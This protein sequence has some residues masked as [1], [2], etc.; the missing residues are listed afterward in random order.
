MNC[1]RLVY[2]F[3]LQEIP[4][5]MAYVFIDSSQEKI[6]II[7]QD[8]QERY[9][10]Q[11]SLNVDQKSVGEGW[12]HFVIS[13]ALQ[14]DDSIGCILYDVNPYNLHVFLADRISWYHQVL[15]KNVMI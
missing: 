12:N 3:F 15:N 5:E 2:I 1:Y 8:T 10:C 6:M 9:P 14:I 7:D 13:K 4:Q 11:I